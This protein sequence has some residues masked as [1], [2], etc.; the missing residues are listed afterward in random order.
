M[1]HVL[2]RFVKFMWR[3]ARSGPTSPSLLAHCFARHRYFQLQI[4]VVLIVLNYR[5]TQQ[6]A[7]HLFSPH[8]CSQF[9]TT[10]SLEKNLA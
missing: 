8:P 4:N 6:P 2:K 7:A 9:S 5:Q 1:N 10:K 3:Y